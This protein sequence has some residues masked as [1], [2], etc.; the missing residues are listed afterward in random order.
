M[1]IIIG[2]CSKI[3]FIWA[4][5]LWLA[6][7]M[8]FK[9]LLHLPRGWRL[10]PDPW[11]PLLMIVTLEATVRHFDSPDEDPEVSVLTE[12]TEPERLV[13]QIEKV[14][15]KEARS[16]KMDDGNEP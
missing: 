12:A 7:W 1:D 3:A 15:D 16:K 13:A 5:V 2:F 6:A 4:Y 8:V 10:G 9:F 11:P 14:I